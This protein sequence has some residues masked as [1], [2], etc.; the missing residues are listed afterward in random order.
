MSDERTTDHVPLPGS[1]T[2]SPDYKQGDAQPPQARLDTLSLTLNAER[3]ARQKAERSSQ[4]W[5]DKQVE[6]DTEMF[7]MQTKLKDALARV[8]TAEVCIAQLEAACSAAAEL[9]ASTPISGP[10][11]DQVAHKLRAA[12]DRGRKEA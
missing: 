2:Y 4:Y 7:A 11:A 5:H 9:I 1:V 12:L 3:E 10:W 6:H 8:A